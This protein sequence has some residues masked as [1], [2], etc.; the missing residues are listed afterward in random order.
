MG[1]ERGGWE[2]Y[3]LRGGGLRGVDRTEWVNRVGL[4]A[5]SN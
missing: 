3:G 4:K 1:V 2:G 5:V